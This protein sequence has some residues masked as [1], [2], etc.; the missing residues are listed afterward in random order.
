M[1]TGTSS[2]HGTLDGDAA[3]KQQID[4]IETQAQATLFPPANFTIAPAPTPDKLA[5]QAFTS[6]DPT[7]LNLED[8][9]F[10][11]ANGQRP[12]ADGLWALLQGQQTP[13]PGIVIADPATV[14]KV[15]V[16]TAASVKPK[17]YV[18]QAHQ[19]GGLQRRSCR[20][21]RN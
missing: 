7:K 18:G 1:I 4:A 21:L 10:I 2:Y 6:G 13:V 5:H 3:I 11:L 15:A 20:R 9:E 17:E 19:P 12:D 16:T 14:L 8:K